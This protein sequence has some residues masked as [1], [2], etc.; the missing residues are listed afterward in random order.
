MR[1]IATLFLALVCQQ[2]IS[3]K[4]PVTLTTLIEN[5]KSNVI[6]WRREFHQHPELSNRE[7]KTSAKIAAHL[8]AL[9][10]EVKT[11]IATNGVVAILKGGKPGPVIALRA[12]MDGLPVTERNNL[13]YKSTDTATYNKQSVGIMHACGHDSHI[14]ILLG[15]AEVLSKTK[16]EVPGTVVFIFQPAEE[17]PPEGEV[18]GA[19]QMVIE[20]VLDA[21]KVEAIFGLHIQ[22]DIPTGTI[23]YRPGGTMAAVNT[24]KIIITGQ[25]AHGAYP[26][27]SVDPIITSAQI[28]NN[29]QTI[30]SRN[31]NITKNPAV[32]TIGAINGGVRSNIIPERVEM[33]AT[34]RTFSNSDEAMVLQRINSIVQNTAEANGA[35]SEIISIENNH[36]PVTF[37]DSALAEKML[38]AL[39]AATTSKVL[40]RDPMTGAE[41]FSF[42]QQKVPGLFFFLGGLPKGNDPLKAP[43]HHTPD[44]IIDDSNLDVGVK[45]F[46]NL[47]F[48]YASQKK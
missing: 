46:C 1:I 6:K 24:L 7:F 48:L 23:K 3:Q 17:G 22:A 36:Y 5:E 27:L 26:W 25:Q 19:K 18:G 45:A 20:G 14:A 16:S 41:D 12:D 32:V 43:A 31:V 33:L 38:P 35:K 8:K 44:F 30:V 28:I 39:Q 40:L 9:G 42:Y 2:S 4:L 29:L 34:V 37:N 10:L 11:G 13:P 47:V 21:P 15:T